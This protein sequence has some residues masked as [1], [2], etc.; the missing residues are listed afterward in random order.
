MGKSVSIMATSTETRSRARLVQ[1]V[2][3]ALAILD[4]FQLERPLLG[5][6]ELSRDLGLNK[7]TVSRLLST[8]CLYRAGYDFQHTGL[9]EAARRQLELLV[10]KV[11]ETAHLAVYDRGDMTY[12][13]VVECAAPLRVH[14]QL[15]A[16]NP[17]YTVA[18]GKVCLAFLDEL[19]REQYL[20]DHFPRHGDLIAFRRELA[21]ARDRGFAVNRGD[22][23]PGV[24]GVA[25]PVRDRSGAVVAAVTI[26]GPASRLIGG[27]V[28]Q[29]AGA[30]A[31]AAREVSRHLGFPAAGASLSEEHERPTSS[32]R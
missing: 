28:N 32:V 29:V 20:A 15:G 21:E 24:I 2:G 27:R 9:A 30:V 19:S 22:W 16:R 3:C 7:A 11:G 31:A 10:P 4:C 25:A 6:S 17:A 14:S 13:D 12:L 1:S 8:L 18:S 5:V 23:V 26:S